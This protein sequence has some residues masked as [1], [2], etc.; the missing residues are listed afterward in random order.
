MDEYIAYLA[1][2]YHDSS[3]GEFHAMGVI[4]SMTPEDRIYLN[5]NLRLDEITG[6]DRMIVMNIIIG[7]FSKYKFAMHLL[8]SPNIKLEL[9]GVDTNQVTTFQLLIDSILHFRDYN[10]FNYSI[11][12]LFNKGY[13]IKKTDESYLLNFYNNRIFSQNIFELWCIARVCFKL[14]NYSKIE[15]VLNKEKVFFT[16]LS[17]KQKKPVGVYYPNLLGIANN[18]LLHYREHGDLILY[19]MKYYDVYDDIVKRD[20]KNTFKQRES[21]YFNY[22]PF[23]N[24]EFNH[25]LYELF[26]ELKQ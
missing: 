20:K 25:I 1:E 6:N 23:Q 4:N 14:N 10:M 11:L 26:P 22:K 16:L 5:L 2:F 9:N 21:D 18:A 8:T 15:E 13:T 19:A 17:F 7:D 3:I 12:H 24:T